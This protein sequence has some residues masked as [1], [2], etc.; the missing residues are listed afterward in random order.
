MRKRIAIP[1]EN[2]FLCSHFG[3]CETFYIADTEN[4]EI[5][6]SSFVKPP[7]HEPGLYPAWVKEQGVDEVICGGVGEKAQI[8]FAQQNITLYIGAGI[9]NPE[10]LVRDLLSGKLV[11]GQNACDH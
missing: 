2:G 7:K 9:K 6:S 8:L 3:H 5:L 10:D 4:N 11:T 1:T